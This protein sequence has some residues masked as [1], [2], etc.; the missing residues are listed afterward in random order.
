M[1]KISKTLRE[2]VDGLIYLQINCNNNSYPTEF[3][4]YDEGWISLTRSL[5]YLHNKFG[6]AR[7][8]Q[9]VDM[10]A[11]AKAHYEAGEINLGSWLMQDMEQV[12]KRKKPFA[13]PLEIYRWPRE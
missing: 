10:S 5:E 13:Y 9:L 1:I 4:T 2:L 12:S 8:A 6:K 7:Y 11:Q 3:Q